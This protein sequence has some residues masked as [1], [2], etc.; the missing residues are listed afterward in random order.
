MSQSPDLSVGPTAA[1]DLRAVFP[2]HALSDLLDHQ[3]AAAA[4]TRDL[5]RASN[6]AY[7]SGRGTLSVPAVLAG[8]RLGFDAPAGLVRET[9]VVQLDELVRTGQVRRSDAA[10]LVARFGLE[11]NPGSARDARESMGRRRQATS[12]AVSRALA[13]AAADLCLHPLTPVAAPRLKIARRQEIVGAVLSLLQGAPDEFPARLY[14]HVRVRAELLGDPD[15]PVASSGSAQRQRRHRLA[16]RWQAIASDHLDRDRLPWRTMPQPTAGDEEELSKWL[17]SGRPDLRVP[18]VG[19]VR[20]LI[21][22]GESAAFAA[23]DDV[24]G[25]LGLLLDGYRPLIELLRVAEWA[26]NGAALPPWHSIE[27][28]RGRN[29]R[30]AAILSVAELLAVRGYPDAA[31]T[32][33]GVAQRVAGEQ[34]TAWL[35]F[36]RLMICEA[37]SYLRGAA[38]IEETRKWHT[39]LVK[40]LNDHGA[41]QTADPLAVAH[42]IMKTEH[43]AWTAGVASGATV[44]ELLEPLA[45]SLPAA[46]AEVSEENRQRFRIEQASLRRVLGGASANAPPTAIAE[47]AHDQARWL[48]RYDEWY[49]AQPVAVARWDYRGHARESSEWRR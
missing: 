7:A 25:M 37:V 20:A 34:A 32:Y 35:R 21:A 43:A 4:A 2:E 46:L 17:A 38:S 9:L 5:L 14:A 42:A 6:A 22:D 47:P 30:A 16:Q 45:G 3:A 19:A 40:H 15:F 44:E 27:P 24:Q 28:S 13:A 26:H 36:R 10:A 8:G 12:D 48:S 33:T 31:L 18:T 41:S 11:G 1:Q 29:L 39:A 23:V 49:C